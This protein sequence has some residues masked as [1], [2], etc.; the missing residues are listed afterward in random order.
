[1]ERGVKNSDKTFLATYKETKMTQTRVNQEYI[2]TITTTIEDVELFGISNDMLDN[3]KESLNPSKITVGTILVNL[4]PEHP[5]L[6]IASYLGAY[7]KE[8]NIAT[9]LL[10]EKYISAVKAKDVIAEND[11]WQA[12]ITFLI[13]EDCN[14]AINYLKN[15]IA[16]F[17][18][19]RI[20]YCQDLI[21]RLVQ[22]PFLI[23]QFFS[24]QEIKNGL[25]TSNVGETYFFAGNFLFEAGKYT[26]AESYFSSARDLL[27][28]NADIVY[29]RALAYYYLE[30]YKYAAS[31]FDFVIKHQPVELE[32]YDYL[33]R[34]Y[35]QL[36]DPAS[37]G[38]T[39]FSAGKFLF[40]AGRYA[41]A[42]SYF[43]SAKSL[44][45][46]NTEKPTGNCKPKKSIKERLS[47]KN[48]SRNTSSTYNANQKLL[49]E[50]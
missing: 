10:N 50:D 18:D 14:T 38:E 22:L 33:A 1:L 17:L 8:N 15:K 13:L 41:E 11:A 31:D 39:Y 27:P 49:R 37:V 24:A 23:K 20:E 21:P 6:K 19:E 12:G 16:N 9:R 44:L 47:K 40:D 5:A 28:D 45:P 7:S 4:I 2:D 30:Q 29:H 3:I 43:A 48:P 26:E 35:K 34:S 46:D 36:D 32:V 42:E 25:N